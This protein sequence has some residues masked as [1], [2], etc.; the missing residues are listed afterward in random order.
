MP[1]NCMMLCWKT[2]S[3]LNSNNFSNNQNIKQ[4]DFQVKVVSDGNKK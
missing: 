2:M 4:K 3:E 1:Q